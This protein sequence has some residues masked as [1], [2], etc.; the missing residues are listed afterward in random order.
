MN[1]QRRQTLN[2]L[3]IRQKNPKGEEVV[4][5]TYNFLTGNKEYNNKIKLG[6]SDVLVIEGIHALDKRVLTNISKIKYL[7][8]I[9]PP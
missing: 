9:F 8:F 1:V 7:E 2:Y 5:P 4:T 6:N 3:T